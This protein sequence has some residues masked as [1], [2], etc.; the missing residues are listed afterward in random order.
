MEWRKE[1]TR[2]RTWHFCPQCSQWPKKKTA[3]A[4]TE[5]PDTGTGCKE[6]ISIEAAGNCQ[7]G[8]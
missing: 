7:P 2:S 1:S 4:V 3:I 6:C 8:G 5:K